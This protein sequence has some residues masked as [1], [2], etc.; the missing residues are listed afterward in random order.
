M[1]WDRILEIDG[2][3]TKDITSIEAVKKLTGPEG[4]SVKIKIYRE[5]MTKPMDFVI[6]RET[7]KVESVFSKVIDDN[8]GYLRISQFKDDTASAVRKA[9]KD[10]A[11]KKIKGVIVDVRNDPG[12]LLNRA[13]EVCDMFLPKKTTHCFNQGA[14]SGQQS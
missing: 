4:T 1:P 7:I 3:S 13:V 8:I 14:R 12:G 5:G 6:R 10:F 11:A 9:L 2:K